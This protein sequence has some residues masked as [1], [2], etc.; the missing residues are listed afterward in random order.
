MLSN[1]ETFVTC[2]PKF[3]TSD[4]KVAAFAHHTHHVLP[5][6][7]HILNADMCKK[8]W[9]EACE[10]HIIGNWKK[11]NKWCKTFTQYYSLEGTK[12]VQ[13]FSQNTNFALFLLPYLSVVCKSQNKLK[14]KKM[15]TKFCINAWKIKK[16]H[17]CPSFLVTF[18]QMKERYKLNVNFLG[19]ISY[20]YE[21]NSML[22]TSWYYRRIKALKIYIGKYQ[23]WEK[24]ET[25]MTTKPTEVI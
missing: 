8:D 13:A 9:R 11:K 23:Y 7:W 21:E 24:Y 19:F 1:K 20:F 2:L 4:A 6:S 14:L 18:S 3:Y 15:G 22:S 16:Q 17:V 12:S 25:R 10:I 5:D